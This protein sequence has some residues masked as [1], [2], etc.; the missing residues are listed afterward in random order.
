LNENVGDNFQIVT[1]YFR[2]KMFRGY[3]D[4]SNKPETYKE[5]NGTEKYQLPF[6]EDLETLPFDETVR[7]RKSIR[8]FS[9]KNLN[10][11]QL[12]YLLW[13][14]TGIQRT[15]NRYEFRNAPSAGALYP[16]ETYLFVNK[17]DTLDK[18]LYHYNIR[19]H[20]LEELK[21]GDFSIQL[22]NACLNQGMLASAAVVLIWS[23]IFARSKWKYKQRAYRYIYLDCGHIAQNLA[24]GAT[25]LGLGSCQVGAFYDDELNNFVELD[26]KN[27][28]VIYLSA[29]GIPK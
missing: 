23:G 26:G 3:L 5:Y 27:E 19:L 8:R 25:S 11:N 1:K 10:L 7:K 14:S 22:K 28:S 13:I 24:L 4:W 17:V 18:G 20:L 15:E 9:K 21:I 12:S 6:L 29:I 2:E 16:I